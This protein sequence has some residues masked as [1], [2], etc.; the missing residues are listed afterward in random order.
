MAEQN[1]TTTPTQQPQHNEGGYNANVDNTNVA[2]NFI[3]QNK[4]T[5]FA[6]VGLLLVALLAFYFLLFR[7][8][9]KDIEASNKMFE[10]QFYFEQNEFEKALKGIHEPGQTETAG[11]LDI[12]EEYGSSQTGNLAHFYAGICLLQLGQF[13][14]SIEYLQKYSGNDALSQAFAY[15]AIGDAKSELNQMDEALSFYEKAAA[16]KPNLATTP[17]FL[18]KKARLLEHLGKKDEAKT[19]YE[20]VQ[21]EYPAYAERVSVEKDLIRLTGKYE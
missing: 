17:Y 12:I 4:T 3:E 2:G 14:E 7:S 8:S 6:G 9:G 10:A 11:F 21:K 15:G 5:I 19:A 18:R 20:A 13:E 16:Y 1:A